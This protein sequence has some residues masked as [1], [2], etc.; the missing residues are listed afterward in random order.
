MLAG[1]L[2]DGWYRG[3]IGWDPEDDR[4][5]YGRQLGLL[6]QLEVELADGGTIVVATDENWRASTGEIRSADHYDGCTIDLRQRQ[7]GWD[8]PGLRR[9]LAGRRSPSCP[10]TW[11]SWSRRWRRP[12]GSSRRSAR[13]SCSARTP[14]GRRCLDAGQNVAGVV[15]LTVRGEAGDTVT[16]RHAE[17]LEPDGDAAHPVAAVGQG[18]RHL[19]PRRRRRP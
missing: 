5:R 8:R 18:H 14:T 9:Q 13:G 3:R 12:S 7:D 11:P 15:R 10:S 6:A 4:G 1:V 16:V 19:R 2:G 17:V